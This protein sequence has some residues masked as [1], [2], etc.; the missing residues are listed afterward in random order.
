VMLHPPETPGATIALG[1]KDMRLF[2]EAAHSA[3]VKTPLGDTFA[4][5]LERA[6]ESGMKDADW[7]AGYYRLAKGMTAKED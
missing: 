5:H 2:R 3:G 6:I 7:A 1:E 4:A